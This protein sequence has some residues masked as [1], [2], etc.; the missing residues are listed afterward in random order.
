MF[1]AGTRLVEIDP[2]DY[3]LA[4]AEA[5]AQIA[6]LDAELDQ[7][8]TDQSGSGQ[9]TAGSCRTSV[10]GARE[11]DHQGELIHIDIKKLGRFERVGHRITG[12]RQL[13]E[14]RGAGF[15][16]VHVAIDDASRLAFSQ[17]L[18]DEKKQSAI[19]FPHGRRGLLL[20]PWRHRHPRHDRQRLVLSLK[21]VP[22]CLPQPRPQ[23]HQIKALA[24]MLPQVAWASSVWARPMRLSAHIST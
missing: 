4:I 11:R 21:R 13:G 20:P 2:T 16:F 15:E 8:E 1:S 7:L 19:A 12:N 5:E 22:D 6:G 9:V 14:S 23:T 17:I 10:R 3:E 18:S 24:R